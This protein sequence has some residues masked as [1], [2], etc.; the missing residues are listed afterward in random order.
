MLR[1][2]RR[3]REEEQYEELNKQARGPGDLVTLPF[4]ASSK[5][6]N[7]LE[8]RCS[9]IGLL[10]AKA[11]SQYINKWHYVSSSQKLIV[12]CGEHSS[13]CAVK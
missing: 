2:T 5:I 1:K 3:K 11:H 6:C 8:R 12:T 4:M 7:I 10:I 9:R 13:K